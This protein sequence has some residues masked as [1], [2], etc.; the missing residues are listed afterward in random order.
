ME[1][2][3]TESGRSPL[4][5]PADPTVLDRTRLLEKHAGDLARIEVEGTTPHER[6]AY[7]RAAKFDVDDAAARLRET[8]RWRADAGIDGVMSDPNWRRRER[9]HRRL[10]AYDYLGTERYGRP[11]MVERVGRWDVTRVLEAASGDPDAFLTLHCMACETLLRMDRPP[12]TVDDRGQVVIMDCL[13][14]TAWHLDPRLAAAFGKLAANDAAHYPDTLARIFVVNAPYLFSAVAALISPF[15]DPDT[16]SKVHVSSG[17]PA[18]L[19][20]CVGEDCLPAELGGKRT[21]VFPY[22]EEAQVS[23]HPRRILSAAE[24]R[25]S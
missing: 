24:D 21:G 16:Y 15:M 13:G 12:G 4:R 19:A 9:E 5:Y 18:E 8:V 11:A 1:G 6:L 23:E 22:D 2:D 25:P 17:V 10:L 7:L 14:L 3:Q 20:D